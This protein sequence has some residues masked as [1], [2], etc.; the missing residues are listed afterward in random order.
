MGALLR[1][2][3]TMT[4][5]LIGYA[6]VSTDAQDVTGSDPDLLRIPRST[7]YAYLNPENRT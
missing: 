2:T 7:A 5:K 4:G 3:G 6:R 1:H